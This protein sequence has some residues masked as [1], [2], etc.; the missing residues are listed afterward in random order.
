LRDGGTIVHG[1]HPSFNQP[2]R[3]AVEPFAKS[4]GSKDAL[5]L[6]R[7]QKYARTAEQLAEIEV[8]RQYCAVQIVPTIEG[9]PEQSLL[10]MREWMAEH[11]DVVVAIGGRHSASSGAGC[12]M[13]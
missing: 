11:S 10:P 5:I 3:E 8:Q 9:K 7:S 2:L 6:V 4:G 1:S 12:R 13:N